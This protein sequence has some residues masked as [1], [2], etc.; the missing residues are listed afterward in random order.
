MKTEIIDF[1]VMDWVPLTPAGRAQHEARACGLDALALPGAR[2]EPVVA[3]LHAECGSE[4]PGPDGP[5]P[6]CG[7]LR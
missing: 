4:L 2:P 6:R 3:F 1:G 5:C 7:P